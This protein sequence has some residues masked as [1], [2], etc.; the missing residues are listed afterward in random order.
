MKKLAILPLILAYA[1][2]AHA[3][4]P[5]LDKS[6]TTRYT[7]YMSLGSQTIN[8]SES[9]CK[10]NI[11]TCWRDD[12]GKCAVPSDNSYSGDICAN[13]CEHREYTAY[14]IDSQTG[15][16]GCACEK[17]ANLGWQPYKTGVLRYYEVKTSSISQCSQITN[18]ATDK[19]KCDKGYYGPNNDPNGCKACPAN[20]TCN[21]GTSFYCNNGYYRNGNACTICPDSK[22]GGLGWD[23]NGKGVAAVGGDEL[24][25]CAIAPG[26]TLRDATGTFTIDNNSVDGCEYTP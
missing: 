20:A 23:A 8:Y 2:Y 22:T 9:D 26:T 11:D 7:N 14:I 24:S 25:W 12:I 18:V 3:T 21:G 5:Y 1:T 17:V 15:E 4:P 16:F 10:S 13:L 19:Y 6:A